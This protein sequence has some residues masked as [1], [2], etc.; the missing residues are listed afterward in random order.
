M[1][2]PKRRSALLLNS[3]ASPSVGKAGAG[4]RPACAKAGQ[5]PPAA[6]TDN[7]NTPSS[8][9][10]M[11]FKTGCSFSFDTNSAHEILLRIAQE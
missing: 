8:K 4:T 11:L 5:A 6:K 2:S 1:R 10:A 3:A 9:A 7:A